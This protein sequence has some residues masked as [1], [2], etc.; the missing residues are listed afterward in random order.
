MAKISCD[1][2]PCTGLVRL[3]K[4]TAVLPKYTV[5][6]C[7]YREYKTMLCSVIEDIL[8]LHTSQGL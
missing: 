4:H 8:Y 5:H 3:R 2:T 6:D 1:K 7:L